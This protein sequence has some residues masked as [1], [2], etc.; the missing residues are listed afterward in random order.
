MDFSVFDC[1]CEENI[2]KTCWNCGN[3]TGGLNNLDTVGRSS[4]SYTCKYCT[5]N[6]YVILH[7][8]L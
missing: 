7:T 6:K 3:S 4:Y 2:L 1:F 5:G 8:L